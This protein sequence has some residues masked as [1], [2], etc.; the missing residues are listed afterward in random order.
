MSRCVT[1]DAH[2]SCRKSETKRGALRKIVKLL[3]GGN[4]T[5]LPLMRLSCGHEMRINSRS[6]ARC[7]QCYGAPRMCSRGHAMTP[8]NSYIRDGRYDQC[9]TCRRLKYISQVNV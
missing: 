4:A 8:E 9:R 7:V 2:I 1:A 3:D 6:M 5:L